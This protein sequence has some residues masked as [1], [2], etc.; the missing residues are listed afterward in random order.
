MISA[1]PKVDFPIPF[2]VSL[3]LLLAVLAAAAPLCA[4]G[5]GPRPEGAAPDAV[6][7]RLCLRRV[8]AGD[9]G[10]GMALVERMAHYRVPG[11]AIAVIDGGRIDWVRGYGV[12]RAGTESP[13]GPDTPFQVAS[14]SKPVTA[15]AVLS[16][17]GDGRLDLQMPL[18]RWLPGWPGPDN[19]FATDQ[20]VTLARLLSH[21]A[22]VGGHSYVGYPRGPDLPTTADI[23]AG[24]APANSPPV[25]LDTLPG[26]LWRYSSGGDVA[27][28]AVIETV[29]GR[30]F[31]DVVRER[32]LAPLDMHHS[33]FTVADSAVVAGGHRD[34]GNP[35]PGGW[36]V[37]PEQAAAGLWSSAADLAHFGIALMRAAAGDS[38]GEAATFVPMLTPLTAGWGPGMAM[39]GEGASLR[40]WHSGANVGYRALL[41]VFPHLG[42]GAVILC[43]GD[44]G[45]PLITEI[46]RAIAS[47][48]DWPHYRPEVLHPLALGRAELA[49]YVGRY[50]LKS[51][52]NVTVQ[53]DGAGVRVR[54]NRQ[55]PRRMVPVAAD[56][57]V[58]LDCDT[59]LR[60]RREQGAVTGLVIV[61]GRFQ[62]PAERLPESTAATTAP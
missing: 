24:R 41:V 45:G 60:F 3:R 8:V 47:V 6:E 43:N 57:F 44:G 4:G 33:F 46:V 34:T 30:P 50:R 28:Q 35:V 22:G 5:E 23:L 13:V 10:A 19:R 40:L 29:T 49:A 14:I 7:S 12:S 59:R 38:A 37:Y 26:A 54:V 9:P 18:D 11:V 61:Q 16:L 62:V 51:G 27:V 58:G 42:R 53:P 25:T 56:T 20:P 36:H 2:I 31:A 15:A 1:H 21:T 55:A 39:G 17:V 48:Y 32:V 52:L